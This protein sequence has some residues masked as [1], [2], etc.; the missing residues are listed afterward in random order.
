MWRWE[1]S[2]KATPNKFYGLRPA[3]GPF[4][5]KIDLFLFLVSISTNM[6]IDTF[7]FSTNVSVTRES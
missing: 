3:A 1:V 7:L 5:E 6:K 4:L 2:N